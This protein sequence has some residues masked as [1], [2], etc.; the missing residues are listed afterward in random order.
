MHASAPGKIIL[1]GEHAVVYGRAAIAVPVTQVQARAV[2]EGDERGSGLTLVAPDV[3]YRSRLVEAEPDDPLAAVVRATLDHLGAPPPDGVLTVT[4]SIPISS[5]MGSGAAVSTA[6]VRALANFMGRELSPAE[7]SRLVYEA[8]K[9]H[10]GTPSGIDNTVVAY[11]Q[12]VYFVR[13]RQ[14]E[15]FAAGAPLSFLIADSGLPSRTREVVGDVRSAWEADT[16]GYETLFD[17]VGAVAVAARRAMEEGNPAVL[18]PLMDENHQLL[19]EMNVSSPTLDR[20]VEAAREAGAPGA[21]LSGAGRGGNV[22]ALV[23]EDS[24]A[25]EQAFLDAGARRVIRTTVE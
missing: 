13:G 20:F 22:I 18:G 4:S 16:A 8:E 2:V 1:F 9:L 23:G 17:R 7:T 10:H 24:R 25:V 5:G 15:T 21:K 11:G 6:V 19:R 3:D 12:P 14:P